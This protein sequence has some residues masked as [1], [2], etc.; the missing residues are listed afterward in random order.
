M[1]ISRAY[2]NWHMILLTVF[3]LIALTRAID[4]SY[5]VG[6]GLTLIMIPA[7]VVQIMTAIDINAREYP[8]F[9]KEDNRTFSL[10]LTAYAVLLICLFKAEWTIK[11]EPLSGIIFYV[12][13]ALI[14]TYQISLAIR[15]NKWCDRKRIK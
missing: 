15:I 1:K 12:L 11:Y 5:H 6:L 10:L 4:P 13:P 7:V 9:F 8:R 3:V 14:G 2:F